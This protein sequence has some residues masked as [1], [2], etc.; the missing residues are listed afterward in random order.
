MAPLLLVL[1]LVLLVLL[2]AGA[3]LVMRV[4]WLVALALVAVLLI[5][6]LFRTSGPRGTRGRRQ[7]W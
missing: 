6:F 1:L 7:P 5:G 3:G 4:L 2:L